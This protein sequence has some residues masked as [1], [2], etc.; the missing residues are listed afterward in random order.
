LCYKHIPNAK[1]KKLEDKSEPM[2]LVGYHSN[3]AYKL[4][5]LVTKK[6][7]LSRDAVVMENEALNW[8]YDN[9]ENYGV[10]PLALLVLNLSLTLSESVVVSLG[11]E[12][13]GSERADYE[14]LVL[15]FFL[16]C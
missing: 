5:N 15:L 9:G 2:I 7:S 12:F 4:M 1:R 13:R 10:Q 11:S 6:M 16:F 8:K 3:G 14:P